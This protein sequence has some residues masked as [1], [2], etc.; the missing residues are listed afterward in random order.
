MSVLGRKAL[1]TLIDQSHGTEQHPDRYNHMQCWC[2]CLGERWCVSEPTWSMLGRKVAEPNIGDDND[3]ENDDHVTLLS[4]HHIITSSYQW[5]D[6]DMIWYDMMMNLKT[7]DAK[8]HKKCCIFVCFFVTRCR[9]YCNLQYNAHLW[10][11][12][13]WSKKRDLT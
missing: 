4:H 11:G 13:K 6:D 2:Q 12:E 9:M 10:I 8:K 1:M 3:N 5:Y 7:V